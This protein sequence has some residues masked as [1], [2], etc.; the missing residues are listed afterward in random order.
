M[1]ETDKTVTWE[2]QAYFMG[3]DWASKHHAIVVVDHQGRIILDF[4]ISHTNEGWSHLR[5]QLIQIAGSDSL[6]RV[7]VAIET[8]CGLAVEQLLTLGCTVYPINPKA[9]QRY[10][11]RKAPS[12]TKTDRLDALSFA[13]ALRTDG[14]NWRQ[15]KP[16]SPEIQELRL[17]CRDEVGLI[18][19]RTALVESSVPIIHV[20][21]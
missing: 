11:D 1:D 18:C 2:S 21:V 5:E 3:F 17:L 13:D 12:G 20:P 7:A 14:H 4:Q 6:W 19:Q 9:A 16:Q 8:T 10:R 15:L